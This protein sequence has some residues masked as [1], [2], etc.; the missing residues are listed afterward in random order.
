[1]KAY[2][3]FG[4]QNVADFLNSKNLIS[5]SQWGFRSGR[6]TMSQ[7]LLTK[8]RLVDA[9]NERAFTDAVY[10]DLSKAFDSTSHKKI[11]TKMRAY[12]ITHNV[13]T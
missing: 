1:M 9:F 12:G 3:I 5:P 11:Q 4:P 13:C 2:A 6:S 7:L 8:S 10:I